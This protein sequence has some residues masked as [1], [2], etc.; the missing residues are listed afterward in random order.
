[1]KQIT[2]SNGNNQFMENE[3]IWKRYMYQLKH[4]NKHL[5]FTCKHCGI[6]TNNT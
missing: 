2:V 1:M 3:N 5:V 6:I 4:F